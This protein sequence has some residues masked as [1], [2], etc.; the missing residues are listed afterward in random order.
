MKAEKW[1]AGA[2]CVF[3]A[4]GSWKGRCSH[5]FSVSTQLR[6]NLRQKQ[7]KLS[8]AISRNNPAERSVTAGRWQTSGSG[9]GTAVTLPR[10]PGWGRAL[11]GRELTSLPANRDLASWAP[12]I[13]SYFLKPCPREISS[14]T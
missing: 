14:N 10:L 4:L 8:S 9:T 2:G 5:T 11:P 6:V 1:M 7:R 3:L 12:K 13:P